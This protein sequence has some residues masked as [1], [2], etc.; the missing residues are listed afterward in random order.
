MVEPRTRLF[1]A[2]AGAVATAANAI[3]PLGRGRLLSMPSFVLGLAPSEFP[4]HTGLLQ[5]SIGG[6]LAR[7]GGTRGWR[8]MLG[9]A[10]HAA[11]LAGLVAVYRTARSTGDVLEAALV[12][13]LGPDYRSSVS[14]P[15]SPRPEATLTSR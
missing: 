9:I 2:G 5:L 8:G 7:R 11:S 6:F 10:A 4:L 1:I 13:A 3:R 14:E 12:E 15:F